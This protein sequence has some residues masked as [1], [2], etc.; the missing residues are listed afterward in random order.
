MRSAGCVSSAVLASLLAATLPAHAGGGDAAPAEPGRPL[1]DVVLA[2]D[3]SGSVDGL[4]PDPVGGFLGALPP[5]TRLAV[6][7]FGDGASIIRPL[8]EISGPADLAAAQQRI[9]GLAFRGRHTELGEGLLL[10]LLEGDGDDRGAATRRVVLL[11][12]GRL[13]PTAGRAAIPEALRSLRNEIL[14]A[15]TAAGMPVFTVA[16]GRAD[17]DLLREVSERTGGRCAL[18][19]D[20]PALGDALALLARG[21]AV[22]A[23]LAAP[24]VRPPAAPATVPASIPRAHAPRT[25]GRAFVESRAAVTALVAATA[26]ILLAVAVAVR[27]RGS[28]LKKLKL[29]DPAVEELRAKRLDLEDRLVSAW[30]AER[31]ARDGQRRIAEELFLVLDH[32]DR[33][34]MGASGDDRLR[35]FRDKLGRALAGAGIDEIRVAV[36]DAFD[37]GVHRHVGERDADLPRGAVLAVTR[38]GYVRRGE[39]ERDEEC[40]LRPAE[41]VLSSGRTAQVN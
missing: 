19:P 23:E 37:G 30:E 5:R 31:A 21:F 24:N 40:V 38:K 32:L 1:L 29:P 3:V 2:V 13:D 39:A 18:A 26:A 34:D 33:A 36:G 12:D 14:P 15:F 41:V 25:V 10:A 7:A 27:W 4:A 20:G 8:S 17:L 6:V 11:S 35:W 16:R 9:S 28:A 22:E